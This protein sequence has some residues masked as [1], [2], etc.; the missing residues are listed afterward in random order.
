[1]SDKTTRNLGKRDIA[2]ARIRDNWSRAFHSSSTHAE[3]LQMNS[4]VRASIVNCPNWVKT[5]VEGYAK[6]IDDLKSRELTIYGGMY[7]GRFYSTNSKRADYYGHNGIDPS[8]FAD[9]GRVTARGFYWSHSLK[10]FF[11]G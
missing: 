2:C 1:M 11:I 7:D 6:A 3:L 8:D 5:Y 9:D 10:P 4:E